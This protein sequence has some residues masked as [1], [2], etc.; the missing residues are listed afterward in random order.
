MFDGQSQLASRGQDRT[1]FNY[2]SNI[3]HHEPIIR[4][5]VFSCC[6]CSMGIGKHLVYNSSHSIAI[7]DFTHVFALTIF[8][9]KSHRA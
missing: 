6:D 3:R 8:K 4:D 2:L 1:T 7:Y 9:S 5:T